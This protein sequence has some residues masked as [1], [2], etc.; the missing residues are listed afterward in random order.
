MNKAKYI[1]LGLIGALIGNS[2]VFVFVSFF[3]DKY[4]TLADW[5]GGL[6]TI[7]AFLAV[8]WQVKKEADVQRAMD[9]ENQRP[10]FAIHIVPDKELLKTGTVF[11]GCQSNIDALK[12]KLYGLKNAEDIFNREFFNLNDWED[13]RSYYVIKNISKNNIY[14]ITVNFMYLKN[15][16]LKSEKVKYTG[17][18]PYENIVIL[19]DFYCEDTTTQFKEMVVKFTSSASEVGFLRYRPYQDNYFYIKSKNKSVST[20]NEDKIILQNSKEYEELN[21]EMEDRKN[22]FSNYW[23]ITRNYD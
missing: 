1:G 13:T 23:R 10:H 12:D 19:T 22:I 9:I 6:G 3:S 16:S 14:S 18:K 21:F 20:V 8:F 7:A 17:V 4:G 15:K 11:I 5:M 2:V